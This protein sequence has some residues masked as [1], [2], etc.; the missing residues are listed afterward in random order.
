MNHFAYQPDSVILDN[1]L[2]NYLERVRPNILPI[3]KPYNGEGEPELSHWEIEFGI[4]SVC[5]PTLREA[6]MACMQ[7]E[8]EAENDKPFYL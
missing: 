3:A 5:R 4:H 2:L 7:A 6:I 8:K 1:E